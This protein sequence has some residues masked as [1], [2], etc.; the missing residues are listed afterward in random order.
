MNVLMQSAE[1]DMTSS[2]AQHCSS[3]LY[4][5]TP[6]HSHL[7]LPLPLPE[8]FVEGML[9]RLVDRADP[10][11]RSL[12]RDTV[13]YVVPCMCECPACWVPCIACV[14]ALHVWVAC[15]RGWPPSFLCSPRPAL[16]AVAAEPSLLCT[17]KS[18]ATIGI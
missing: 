10:V 2:S 6:P 16:C 4:S 13:F 7:V 11:S 5:T 14:G 17:L 15:M 1:A 8:W 3:C 18:P 9:R 12:L